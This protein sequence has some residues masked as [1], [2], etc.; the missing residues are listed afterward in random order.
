MTQLNIWALSHH[1][2][3]SLQE[4][5]PNRKWK[6]SLQRRT[7]YYWICPQGKKKINRPQPAPVHLQ[8]LLTTYQY[9]TADKYAPSR[10]QQHTAYKKCLWVSFPCSLS[11]EKLFF[12]ESMLYLWRG[13]G[14]QFGGTTPTPAVKE[15]LHRN[16]T[17]Q[18]DPILSRLVS[19]MMN[20]VFYCLVLLVVA[21]VMGQLNTI[22]Q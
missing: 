11:W 12:T 3:C 19:Y 22:I 9:R 8:L 16:S 2:L 4:G 14:W 5:T 7:V 18:W 1:L 10:I 20:R 6:L 13:H 15:R 21:V 17:W